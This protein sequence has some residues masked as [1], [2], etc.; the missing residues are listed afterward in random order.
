MSARPVRTLAS[1]GAQATTR[2]KLL[3]PDPPT[4]ALPRPV[5]EERIR[6]GAQHRL[7]I[8]VGPTGQGKTTATAAA[9][10]GSGGVGWVTLDAT[11]HDQRRLWTNVCAVLSAAAG[12]GPLARGTFDDLHE[13]LV[14]VCQSL[15]SRE[16]EVRLVIDDAAD[17]LS[18]EATAVPLGLL[19]DWLPSTV[20]VVLLVARPPAVRV[21]RRRA[22][23]EAVELTAADL[24]FTPAEVAAYLLRSWRL[25]LDEEAYRSVAAATEGWPVLLPLAA[26]RIAGA[27][28]PATAAQRLADDPGV[29]TGFVREL[30]G[31]LSPTDRDRLLELSVLDEVD[32][33]L[34]RRLT[35]ELHGEAFLRELVDRG[36]LVPSSVTPGRYRHRPLLRQALRV[37]L[38]T[39]YPGR[40]CAAHEIAARWY[41]DRGDR[42]AA[43][44]HLIGAGDTAAAS[45]SLEHDLAA[46]VPIDGGAWVAAALHRLPPDVVAAHPDLLRTMT[47]L[48]VAAGDRDAL[49]RLLAVVED[50]TARSPA[51]RVARRRVRADLSRLRGDGVEPLLLHRD[52]H[53]LDPV[54]FHPLGVALAAEG[55]HDA[56]SAALQ[57]SLDD[58]RR[59]GAPVR[60]LV[61]LGDLAWQRAA[62]GYLVDADLL[63]RR[64]THLATALCRPAVP[65]TID[66]ARA[67]VA[68]DRGRGDVAL[69]H[70][71]AARA[72]AS[73]G[74]D[75][76]VH[77]DVMMFISRAHWT[78]G[79]A[80]RA[81]RALDDLDRELRRH[82]LGGGLISRVRRTRASACLALDDVA[83]A[84]DLLPGITGPVDE[85]PPEDRLIA[86]LI[87]LRRG[88]A[89]RTVQLI[90]TVRDAGIGPR[91]AIHALHIDVAAHAALG[92]EPGAA[93]AR[94][95]AARITRGVGLLAGVPCGIPVPAP[96]SASA[97]VAPMGGPRSA[98]SP[99]AGLTPRELAV[100]R[101]L[102]LGTNGEIALNLGVSVN[103][104]KTHIK[105]IYRKFGVTSREGA[106]D[107]ALALRVL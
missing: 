93:A 100:L 60:E 24:D 28:D 95:H 79:D 88:D 54:T 96:A 8:V 20:H 48:A 27:P 5:L 19:L 83:G 21:E 42:A 44:D 3:P 80:G 58:A 9:L 91:L 45:T 55:R 13:G 99:L 39:R 76:A 53:T 29:V 82:A 4:Y 11:D 56:A 101:L 78:Q 14:R 31:E 70:A 46:L 18:D 73:A 25:L 97:G 6:A 65:A 33:E 64:A 62:A 52:R 89:A 36:F 98:S 94:R 71:R 105:S 35:D 26:E 67:Q 87:H 74:H 16:R 41:A 59:A 75:F 49:E 23:G 50:A 107:R 51:N 61:I 12:A 85:L 102:P 69:Q 43:I 77:A 86:A 104:V 38:Q 66:L 30:L 68:L 2:R 15:Q 57:T 37:E 22:R 90:A 92:D 40:A 63:C 103:T 106:T 32:P 7:L 1:G 72:T 81:A 17:V 34:C 47:D 84:I 10:A